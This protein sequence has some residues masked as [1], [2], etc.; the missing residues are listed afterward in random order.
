MAALK[1][2]YAT[3]WRYLKRWKDLT[4]GE[5]TAV[6]VTERQI[7]AYTSRRAATIL[8]RAYSRRGDCE[9]GWNEVVRSWYFALKAQA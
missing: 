4:G 2:F 5:V 6:N 7:C 9:M 8:W 3:G 1:G